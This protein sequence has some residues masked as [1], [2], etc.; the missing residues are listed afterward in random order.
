[1]KSEISS[2]INDL[3]RY[4]SVYE[5]FGQ[6]LY[7]KKESNVLNIRTLSSIKFL[8]VS[9]E[10][11]LKSFLKLSLDEQKSY[12]L[13]NIFKT[14]VEYTKELV[15][16]EPKENLKLIE[17]YVTEK[18]KDEVFFSWN[19]ID[20]SI[21]PMFFH[22]I[23]NDIL[24]EKLNDIKKWIKDELDINN[25]KLNEQQK[26]VLQK[27]IIKSVEKIFTKEDSLY[28]DLN[29]EYDSYVYNLMESQIKKNVKDNHLSLTFNILERDNISSSLIYKMIEYFKFKIEKGGAGA[30]ISLLNLKM[31]EQSNVIEKIGIKETVVKA[32]EDIENSLKNIHAEVDGEYLKLNFLKIFN[33][34]LLTGP[35]SIFSDY[36]L[37]NYIYIMKTL[38]NKISTEYYCNIYLD[39]N[40][41]YL[42]FHTKTINKN[43]ISVF[44]ECSSE[45]GGLSF[46]SVQFAYGL[47]SESDV[48]SDFFTKIKE[49]FESLVLLSSMLLENSLVDNK[50]ILKKKVFKF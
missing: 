37:K 36:S 30:N 26:I 24:N 28:L 17:E 45:L 49:S 23:N 1:M 7:K 9:S 12:I 2:F 35:E 18:Y 39:E 27:L 33:Q 20:T 41:N 15:Y 14:V 22:I 31:L 29:Y 6:Q 46:K 5:K 19:D 43:L 47:K 21:N 32:M 4:K 42:K 16:L 25:S 11:T 13:S 10:S 38:I 48:V 3:S 8:E 34:S 40:E 50:K 44:E